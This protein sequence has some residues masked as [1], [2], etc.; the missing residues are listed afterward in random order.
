M[1]WFNLFVFERAETGKPI[2]ISAAGSNIMNVA[3]TWTGNFEP[4]IS[5]M[6]RFQEVYE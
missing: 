3:S 6:L 2:G 1:V 4:V 5:P